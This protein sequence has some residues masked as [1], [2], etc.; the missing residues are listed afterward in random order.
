[1]TSRFLT[2]SAALVVLG[3]TPAL[4]QTNDWLAGTTAYSR[5]DYRATYAD[6]QRQAY[7]NGYRDGVKRGEEAARDRK[8]FN[9]EIERDY[10]SADRGYNRSFG[11]RNRYH[12]NYRGGFSQGYRDAYYRYGGN[13][14]GRWDNRGWGNGNGNGRYPNG[15]YPNGGYPNGG[16]PN[17]GYYPNGSYGNGSAAYGAYQNGVSDGYQKGLDDV[18]DRKRP[19]VTRQKW[20]RS[21]DHDYNNRYGSKDAYRV[22]YRRGFEEGYNRAYRDARRF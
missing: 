4:A 5:D 16:Y 21:G 17:G 2:I 14:N 22:E 13:G 20:Y 8:A 7:D 10:R 12:D 9:V 18:H 11:D 3:S 15:G 6:A 19:D 1:M